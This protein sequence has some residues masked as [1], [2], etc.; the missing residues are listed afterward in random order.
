MKKLLFISLAMTLC[1]F[2]IAQTVVK[3]PANQ[4][5]EFTYPEYDL[6]RVTLKNKSLKGLD[7]AVLSKEN[8]KQVRGF[9]LGMKGKVD[10]LVEAENKLVITNK[11]NTGAKVKLK[12]KEEKRKAEKGKVVVPQGGYI[13]FT[14]RNTSAKSIPLLIP[15]VMN[16]NLSPFSRSGVDLKVGQEIL[17]R[18]NGK[19]YV[20]LTVDNSIKEGDELDI[21]KILKERKAELGLK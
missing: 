19:K 3:I 6:Y 20:L 21:N 17:F 1:S 13:S 4:E 5:L 8:N 15:S 16:P 11:A 12:G 7:V 10:V 9:G 18:A 2:L 14:L